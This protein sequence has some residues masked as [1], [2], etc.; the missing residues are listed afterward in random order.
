MDWDWLWFLGFAGLILVM[1]RFGMGCCGGHAHGGG[2]GRGEKTEPGPD[3]GRT[4]AA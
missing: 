4:T 3:K 2:K 1:R